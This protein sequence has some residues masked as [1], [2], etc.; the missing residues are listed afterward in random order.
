MICLLLLH[1]GDIKLQSIINFAAYLIGASKEASKRE[2]N[3]VELVRGSGL[4]TL[5]KYGTTAFHSLEPKR[6]QYNR[7]NL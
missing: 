6:L 3:S 7:Y 4:K 2:V 1:I 5:I